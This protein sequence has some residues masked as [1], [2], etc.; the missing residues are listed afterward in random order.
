MNKNLRNIL[1]GAAVVNMFFCG[2]F[3]VNNLD[4]S[5]AN[6]N[7]VPQITSE[8]PFIPEDEKLNTIKVAKE[9]IVIEEVKPAILEGKTEKEIKEKL[10]EKTKD[11]DTKDPINAFNMPPLAEVVKNEKVLNCHMFVKDNKLTEQ[12]KF[13]KKED[14]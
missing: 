14:C 10:A 13:I 7:E 6:L 1:L 5:G 3:I 12:D 2:I 4:N 11:I 8:I 9:D